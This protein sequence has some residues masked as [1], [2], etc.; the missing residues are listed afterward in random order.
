MRLAATRVLVASAVLVAACSGAGTEQASAPGGGGES[1]LRPVR[2]ALVFPPNWVQ[3][4]FF[5][6]L[7]QGFYEEEGLEVEFLVPDST[8]TSNRL[9]S[10]G[11]AEL[12]ETF[13]SDP[14]VA[15]GQGLSIEI[16]NGLMPD[17]LVGMMAL[18]DAVS[19][20]GDVEG[21]TVGLLNTPLDR[22][23]FDLLLED[24]GLTQEDVEVIDPGFNLV[25]PL[26]AGEFVASTGS[27]LGEYVTASSEYGEEIRFFPYGDVCPAYPT[28]VIG[29]RQWVADN[30]D[31]VQAFN[32][33]T[34]RGAVFAME[35]PQETYELFVARFPDQEDAVTEAKMTEAQMFYC[36]AHTEENGLGSADLEAWQTLVELLVEE[37]SIGEPY[38]AAELV[39]NDHLPEEPVTTERC[40]DTT[41]DFDPGAL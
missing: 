36:S 27:L 5:A 4:Y 28:A 1:G 22:V 2:F 35:E 16:V 20:F 29:N 26:I 38:D 19:D 32:R 37:G 30:P 24:A 8:T 33:A 13:G 3:G 21:G 17:S 34:L 9:V 39:T 7:D 10:L 31:L 15:Y 23:C 14:L 40:S 12:G 6:A 25:A 18:P 41:V 11:Q